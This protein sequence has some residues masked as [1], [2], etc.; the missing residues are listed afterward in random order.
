MY[1]NR[2]SFLTNYK[3]T[4]F[5]PSLYLQE[6]FSSQGMQEDFSSHFFQPAVNFNIKVIMDFFDA[7]NW[8][9]KF[10]SCFW[11]A[12]PGSGIFDKGIRILLILSLKPTLRKNLWYAIPYPFPLQITFN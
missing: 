7:I 2:T 3:L 9:V 4:S 1:K 11:L 6:F 8:V 5:F 10:R 12:G